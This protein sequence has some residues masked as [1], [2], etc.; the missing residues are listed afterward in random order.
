MTNIR[1]SPK[2]QRVQDG[3][4]KVR[5][6]FDRFYF[7]EERTKPLY[8]ALANYRKEFDPKMGTFK[9]Y[10]RHD[11]N[12]H[13]CFS[14]DTIIK[15]KRGNRKISEIKS[16]DKVA[17][18]FGWTT[19]TW[20]G[21]TSIQV[22]GDYLGVEMTS[23]HPV[24]TSRGFVDVDTMRNGDMILVCKKE[25]DQLEK[26]LFTRGLSL[27]G[28]QNQ[29]G[30]SVVFISNLLNRVKQVI[31]RKGYIGLYGKPKKGKY[32]TDIL[33]TIK[34]VTLLIIN[35]PTWNV[36]RVES[37]SQTTCSN[38]PESNK[39]EKVSK[40]HEYM[41]QGGMGLRMVSNFTGFL[42]RYLGKKDRNILINVFTV[43]KNTKHTSPKGQ[44]TVHLF[45]RGG[46]QGE[47]KD[48]YNLK[49]ESGVFYVNGFVVSNSDAVR[50][51]CA[52][53][54]EEMKFED[55]HQQEAYERK[56]DQSFFG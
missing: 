4:E 55:K 14:G 54:T 18:P 26:M 40:S 45:A 56:T 46:T 22:T 38:P 6:L 12:S 43:K 9:D 7:D 34:M 27:G 13:F 31:L 21:V 24:L 52:M 50:N 39:A 51:G 44:S 25:K 47:E 15:T 53:W 5:G 42:V 37:I 10:P 29:T 19:V 35:Y 32:L 48:V 3:I 23:N 30:V 2:P 8:E 41:P 16:G 20:S 1:V 49:T 36:C 28:T 11:N 33:F 17:S